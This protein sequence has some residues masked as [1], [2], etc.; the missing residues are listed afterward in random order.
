[1]RAMARDIA[2][3]FGGLDLIVNNGAPPIRGFAHYLA[4]KIAK[5]RLVRGLAEEFPTTQF[6]VARLPRILSDQTNVPF[7]FNAPANPGSVA[8]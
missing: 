5:E 3:S 4:A 2:A 8:H 7:S 1:M 6:I